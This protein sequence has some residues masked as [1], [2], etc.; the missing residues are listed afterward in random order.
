LERGF[1]DALLR[2]LQ[3]LGGQRLVEI[4]SVSGTSVGFRHQFTSFQAGIGNVLAFLWLVW[5]GASAFN[6]AELLL[7][8]CMFWLNAFEPPL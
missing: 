6:Q 7:V 1:L 8:H 3:D 5:Y 4:D 2:R